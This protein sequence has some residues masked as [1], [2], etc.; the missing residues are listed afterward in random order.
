MVA[1]LTLDDIA[2]LF[3][4]GG[5]RVYAGEPVTQ[6]E[7]ALQ[8]GL[9]AE[10]AG[11]SA[12]LVSAAFLHDLGHLINDEG[13]TPTLRG[14]DDRHEVVALPRLRGLF[15]E[16]VLAPI[17]LHVQAKRYLCARGDGRLSG[18]Q[19]LAALSAD[20]VRSL[21]LQGGVFDHAQAAA[22][23]A[24]PHAAAAIQVRL[25]DDA[26]KVAG[27]ATPDLNHYLAIARRAARVAPA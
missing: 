17:G 24:R 4:A 5:A 1:T 10:Q 16:D 22:F 21:Q 26:A 20:S 8:S 23:I 3:A 9:A 11:A 27:L 18:A 7:H 2:T 6:L 25:W 19:Y 13:A 14:I 12:A 15:G